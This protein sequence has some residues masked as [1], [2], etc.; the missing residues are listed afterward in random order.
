MVI[1]T[2]FNNWNQHTMG[3]TTLKCIGVFMLSVW[4]FRCLAPVIHAFSSSDQEL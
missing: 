1:P 4:N 3:C 2:N